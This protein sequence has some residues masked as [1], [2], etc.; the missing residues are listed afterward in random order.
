M[1]YACPVCDVVEADAEHL[2]NHLAVTASLHE[3]DHAAWL[4]DHAPDWAEQS[5]SELGATAVEHA[6]K[7]ILTDEVHTHDHD[8]VAAPDVSHVQS[9]PTTGT[10]RQ[11]DPETKRALQEARELMDRTDD[12]SGE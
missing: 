3:G 8:D 2:A 5:P 9:D 10:S 6:E 12:E 1:A 4:E 7:R 11:M